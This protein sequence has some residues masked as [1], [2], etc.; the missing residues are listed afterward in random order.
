MSEVRLSSR[1]A[2][3]ADVSASPACELRSAGDE[4]RPGAQDNRIG[5]ADNR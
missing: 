2:P 3:W 1:T 5:V 4:L